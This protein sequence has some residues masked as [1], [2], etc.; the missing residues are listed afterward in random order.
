LDVPDHDSV[1][2]A[3]R[4]EM[5]RIAEHADMLLWVTDPE[6]YADKAMHDYLA[7]LSGHG[8]VTA[9]VLNKTDQLAPEDADRCLADLGRLLTKAGLAKVPVIGMSAADGDGTDQ[10]TGLLTDTV[11]RRQAMVDRLTADTALAATELLQQ[12]GPGS[13]RREVPKDVERTLAAELVGA[14]GLATVTDAVARGHR[15]DAAS[16]VGWPFTRWA[17][18]LRPHP[19]GRFHLG[20]GSAGRASLPAPSGAQVARVTGAV[21]DT[22]RA[23][24]R[25]LTDPWPDLL[26]AAG[27]PDSAVLNDRIDVAVADAARIGR[28]NSPRWWQLVNLVQLLLAAAV[29]VGVV[30]LGLLAV[31]AYLRIPEPPTPDYRGVPIPTGLLLIGVAVGLVLAFVA[32][33]SARIGGRRR[34][35][36]VTRRAERAV[37]EVA[38]EL[39]ITPLNQELTNRQDLHRLLVTAGGT[40]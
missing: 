31:A 26:V 16:K 2:E 21:R 34:A 39:I 30:W 32:G 23:V 9:M 20:Q 25:D 13:D 37:S 5:E 17:R 6:K 33:R 18:R 15:R 3:H 7:R 10:L 29:V 8:S 24:S 14:S 4:E 27:T 38:D 11:E 22:T 36:A 40:P 19:L 1:A 35:A 28:G 12:L